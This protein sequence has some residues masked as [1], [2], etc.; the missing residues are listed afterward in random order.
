MPIA[1]IIRNEST[2]EL[3]SKFTPYHD[4]DAC[5]VATNDQNVL[6]LHSNVTAESR[7]SR[8]H[9]MHES[10]PVCMKMEKSAEIG[11]HRV[12]DSSKHIKSHFLICKL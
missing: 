8:K 10:F 2:A 1:R 11:K 5:Y 4:N 12:A 6:V 3:Q 7:T 9:T